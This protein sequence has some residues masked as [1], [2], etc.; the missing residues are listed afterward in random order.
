MQNGS[1]GVKQYLLTHSFIHINIAGYVMYYSAGFTIVL[2][3]A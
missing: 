1:F 2:R 3:Y